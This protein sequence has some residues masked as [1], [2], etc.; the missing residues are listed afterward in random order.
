VSQ[1]H[2]S[3]GRV[4]ADLTHLQIFVVAAREGRFSRA[5]RRLGMT[6]S[7]FSRQVSS[8]VAPKVRALVDFFAEELATVDCLTP[9]LR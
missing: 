7:A 8:L 4:L 1:A 9:P 5:V 3:Q 6:S 2:E